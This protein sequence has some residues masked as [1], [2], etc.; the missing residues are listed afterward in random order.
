[1]F[2][3]WLVDNKDKFI[4]FGDMFIEAL[5]DS[6]VIEELAN[7]DLEKLARIFKIIFMG[8]INDCAD[9]SASPVLREIIDFLN[10]RRL[11][12]AES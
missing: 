4:G 1:M 9:G 12:N 5:T 8:S 6:D 3:D 7:R 10:E 2:D 11:D